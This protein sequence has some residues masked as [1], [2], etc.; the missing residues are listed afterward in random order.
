MGKPDQPRD[1]DGKW[2]RR[3]GIGLGGAAIA[4]AIAALGGGL[5]GAGAVGGAAGGS[6][7]GGGASVSSGTGSSGSSA[8]RPGRGSSDTRAV[9]ARDRPQEALARRLRREGRDVERLDGDVATD[10][11]TVSYGQVRAFFTATPCDAVGRALFEVREGGARVVVAVAVVDMPTVDGAVTMKRLV[12]SPGTGNVRE[13]RS[14]RGVR[15]SGQ[16]YH[17]ARDEATVVNAQAE[18]VGA[19]AAAARLAGR[20]SREAAAG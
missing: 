16:H 14:P 12:D 15:W 11:A 3:G 7:A 6:A 8:S 4:I 20:V 5:G 17:S 9:R 18:P 1:K 2:R 10:C 19:G 13:L